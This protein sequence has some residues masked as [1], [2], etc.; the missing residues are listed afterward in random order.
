MST[1]FDAHI[2]ATR[3]RLLRPSRATLSDADLAEYLVETI[4]QLVIDLNSTGEP[5]FLQTVRVEAT[6]G[7]AIKALNAPNFSRARYLYTLDDTNPNANRHPIPLVSPEDLVE[8]FRGGDV[9]PTATVSTS[10]PTFAAAASC[11]Y[12]NE[13]PGPGDV[14]E[15]G[16][17][18]NR[19]ASYRLVYELDVLRAQTRTD[20]GFRLAQFDGYVA[21]LTAI[22]VLPHC[23]WLGIDAAAAA[24]RKTDIA[25]A[26]AYDIGSVDSRRGYSWAYWCFKQS[27]T[28]RSSPLVVGWASDRM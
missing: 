7:V 24:A 2:G 5:W 4:D 21:A 12:L 23:T 15:F 26:C 22:R 18:P 28:Q 1:A 11:Y 27:S 6:P 13:S 17:V 3:R 20:P 25:A 8:L 16:P 10:T 9:A 14:I 19:A